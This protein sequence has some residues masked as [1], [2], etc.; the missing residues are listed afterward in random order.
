MN[1]PTIED[2]SKLDNKLEIILAAVE[3]LHEDKIK[4]FNSEELM[5]RM[6]VSY[7]TFLRMAPSMQ[8]AGLFKLRGVWRMKDTDF[9]K[10]IKAHH[11]N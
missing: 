1:I 8:K 11:L 6:K 9:D 5:L 4:V 3:R 7:R 10:Y 2:Y